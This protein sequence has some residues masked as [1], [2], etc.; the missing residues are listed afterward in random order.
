MGRRSRQR[1][2]TAES[3]AAP[4]RKAPA[5]SGLTPARKAIAG[6][7]VAAGVLGVVTLLGIAVL[8]GTFGPIIVFLVVL[9]FAVVIQRRVAARI[10]D[11]ELSADDRLMRLL[12][13]GVLLIAVVLALVS[14]VVSLFAG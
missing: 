10:A 7:L 11:V 3:T 9:L 14:A 1:F 6:Y 4:T 5:P 13:T 2:S 12:A 8:G